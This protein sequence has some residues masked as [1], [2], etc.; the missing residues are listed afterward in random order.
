VGSGTSAGGRLASRSRAGVAV[1]GLVA[2]AATL[3]VIVAGCGGSGSGGSA[4]R[5]STLEV[6]YVAF[7]DYLDPSLSYSLEGW[8]AMWETYV[9]LLTYVH[10]D[11]AAGTKVVPGLARA[12]PK[13]GDGGHTY[14]LFLRKGLRYSDGT[15]VRASDF[16]STIERVLAMNSPATPF[17]TDIVGAERFAETKRGGIA[18]I[19]T[20]D[21]TGRIVIHLVRPRSTFTNELAMLFAAPL[22]PD[23]KREDLSGDP[24]PGTGPYEIVSSHPGQGWE[25]RRNPEWAKRDGPLLPRVP[26]GHYAAIDVKVITNPETAVNDVESG[27]IDWMEEP[28]PT[29]RYVEL[30]ERFEGSQLLVTQQ[31]DVYYFW[32][33]VNKPP[34]DDLRVRQAVN[35]ATDPAALERLYAGQLRATQ[36]VLPAAMPGHVTL[37]LYPHDMAKAR[38]LIALAEPTHLK[39]TVWTDDFGPNK[40]AGEYYEGVLRELGF[41]PTL[42]VVPAANYLTIIGNG[43]TPDLDTGWA[44]WFIDYP[45]PNDYFEPQLSG[46]SIEPIGDS[47]YSRLNDPEINREIAKLDREPL[48]PRQE[49]AY[50]RLDRDVMEEAPWAPFGSLTLTTF[51]SEEID[52]SKVVVSPVY[53]QDLASFAPH[54]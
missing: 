8:S 12:M 26:S 45:H 17:Y 6:T 2:L 31:I 11:G 20:D 37:H 16:R 19:R 40:Q 34:F 53:G 33:N 3:A 21:A 30:R 43:S 1:L 15:P 35:Y 41:E 10:A 25:Y 23:T 42:K 52:L 24:P 18:G 27:K 38:E 49:A 54:G 44:D 48:G 46:A 5:S 14:T 36:Q 9:P 28:P 51:V 7:P 4:D 22:P 47:N 39:L 50:A 13:I 29:D 32:M